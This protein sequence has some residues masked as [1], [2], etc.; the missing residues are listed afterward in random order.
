MPP[1]TRAW[2]RVALA[3]TPYPNPYVPVYGGPIADI[4]ASD[5][6]PSC[7]QALSTPQTNAIHSPS[8]SPTHPP[9]LTLADARPSAWDYQHY[10]HV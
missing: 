2:N 6:S 3:L 4:N 1:S 7:T 8:H 9:T 10:S 5:V